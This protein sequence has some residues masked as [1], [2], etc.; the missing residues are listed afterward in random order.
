MTPE[1]IVYALRFV[2]KR[3]IE[4]DKMM[5]RNRNGTNPGLTSMF[6][7]GGL[8]GMKLDYPIPEIISEIPLGCLENKVIFAN[9]LEQELAKLASEGV[10]VCTKE[11]GKKKLLVFYAPIQEQDN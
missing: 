2:Q 11:M 3:A 7:A 1:K 10:V 4:E 8:I 5:G 6:L 9:Y